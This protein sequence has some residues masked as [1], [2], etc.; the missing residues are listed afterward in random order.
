MSDQIPAVPDDLSQAL[1]AA[2]KAQARF[3]ALPPSHRAAY[4]TWLAEA[5]KADTRGRRVTK[6]IELLSVAG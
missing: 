4:L 3:N 6:T 5:K 1:S 2:P